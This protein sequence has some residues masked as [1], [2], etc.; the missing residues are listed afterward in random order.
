MQSRTKFPETCRA[1]SRRRKG[2]GAH[3]PGA[4]VCASPASPPAPTKRRGLDWQ[5]GTAPGQQ[6]ALPTSLLFAFPAKLFSSYGRPVRADGI[7]GPHRGGVSGLCRGAHGP[8]PA[9]AMQPLG[10]GGRFRHVLGRA[11]KVEAVEP[12]GGGLFFFPIY[13]YTHIFIFFFPALCARRCSSHRR[14]HPTVQCHHYAP[15]R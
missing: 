3:R 4:C 12:L 10:E 1:P 5:H 8:S 2:A 15:A 9:W 7:V 11:R 13:I 6:P 14:P